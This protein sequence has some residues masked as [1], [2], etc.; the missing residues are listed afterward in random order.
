MFLP[1]RLTYAA[2]MLGLLTAFGAAV[3]AQQTAT[4][5]PA[6]GNGRMGR[7]HGRLQG[8]G[9]GEFGPGLVRELNLTDDQKQQVRSI[10]QQSIAGNKATRD[11]MRQL[12]EK[13]RQGTLSADEQA[14]A[15]AL[16]QQ[17]RTSMKDAHAKI[18][19]V[20]T[21]EQKTKAGELRK[22][23]RGNRE[24]RRSPRRGSLGRP[25]QGTPPVQKPPTPPAN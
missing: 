13:R 24:R 6:E 14:R 1:K 15:L 20:L 2:L 18:A 3:Q 19:G 23:R 7:G 25:G 21:A 12:A 4:Q 11:E 8:P 5:N 9:R 10:M 22:E 16:R 17:M